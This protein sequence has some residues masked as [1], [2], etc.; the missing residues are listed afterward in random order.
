[1]LQSS[2]VSTG[3]T[4]VPDEPA[5][6]TDRIDADREHPAVTLTANEMTPW[7]HHR[8]RFQRERDQHI[9]LCVPTQE[10]ESIG[11]AFRS[12]P[13]ESLQ[14]NLVS[15]PDAT[16]TRLSLRLLASLLG[17]TLI[18]QAFP[19]LA[20]PAGHSAPPSQQLTSRWNGLS[21][22]S[23]LGDA[24]RR[25]GIQEPSGQDEQSQDE[26]LTAEERLKKYRGRLP[27]YF[28]KVINSEQRD[29]IYA[30]QAKYNEQI[31][32]LEMQ[33]EKL[34]AERDQQVEAVLTPE[35]LA[36]ITKMRDEAK[37][38]RQTRDAARK[39]DD[40]AGTDSGN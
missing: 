40:G 30:I 24:S 17:L 20:A 5:C 9:A 23:R 2:I 13:Q 8:R 33:I 15:S 35:Q 28:G 11:S 25:G 26:S 22:I 7:R 37:A 32:A 14:P 12:S 27:N 16:R 31:A 10:D 18:G 3:L 21:T 6:V 4:K 39:S 29:Q 34:S 1:M 36:E 19:A 38:R